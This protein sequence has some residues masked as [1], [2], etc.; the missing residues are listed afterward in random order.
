MKKKQRKQTND[1]V[2]IVIIIFTVLISFG[3]IYVLSTYRQTSN[4]YTYEE[5]LHD[6]DG[7]GLP[8]HGTDYH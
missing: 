3:G 6:H 7:D 1:V 2:V 8:D 4:S 5:M